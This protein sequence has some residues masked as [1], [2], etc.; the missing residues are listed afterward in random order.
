MVDLRQSQC[1]EQRFL[2]ETTSDANV[3]A[4]IANGS[5]VRVRGPMGVFFPGKF[6]HGTSVP[7]LPQGKEPAKRLGGNIGGEG[8]PCPRPASRVSLSNLSRLAGE[9][10]ARS[11]G[12]GSRLLEEPHLT[13]PRKRERLE[14]RRSPR[15]QMWLGR[16]AGSR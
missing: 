12:W 15:P 16:S 3:P 2:A 10:R 9:G 7:R 8:K 1:I 5:G 14:Q 4:R 11:A 13:P 6:R